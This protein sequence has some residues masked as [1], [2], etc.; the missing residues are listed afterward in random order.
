[1]EV[2]LPGCRRLIAVEVR[3]RLLEERLENEIVVEGLANFVELDRLT[4]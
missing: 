1:M 3:V 4:F 2:F